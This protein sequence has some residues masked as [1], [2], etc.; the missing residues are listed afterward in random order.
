LAHL[1]VRFGFFDENGSRIAA[2]PAAVQLSRRTESPPSSR[3]LL[4]FSAP[5][6][7]LP[8]GIPAGFEPAQWL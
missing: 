1:T 7:R 2:P 8:C 3:S 4:A 6:G 5:G